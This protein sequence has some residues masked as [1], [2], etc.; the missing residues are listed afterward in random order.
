MTGEVPLRIVVDGPLGAGYLLLQSGGPHD[1]DLIAPVRG[2][3]E[4]V[5]FEFSLSVQGEIPDGRPRM[6]GPVVQGP[7]AGRF[8][9]LNSAGRR[10]KV[11]LMDISWEMIKQL[12]P[13]QRLEAHIAGRARDGGWACASVKLQPPGWVVA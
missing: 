9:Y 10:A 4:A 6:L 3:S 5:V 1:V 13:G 12:T 8:V 7:P 2:S 11:P